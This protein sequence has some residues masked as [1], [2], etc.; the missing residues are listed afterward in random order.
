M[1]VGLITGFALPPL[2][3]AVLASVPPLC[4]RH[5]W[6]FHFWLTAGCS[7][8]G[9]LVG[10]LFDVHK[11]LWYIPGYSFWVLAAIWYFTRKRRKRAAAL[12]GAKTRALRD[13]LVRKAR[14][15]LQP[16]PVLQPIPVR[17]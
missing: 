9:G 16:R 8:G 7:G 12:A 2:W 5:G 14:E 17:R 10:V 1:I 6:R 3:G 4:R 13:A 11:Y 15:L